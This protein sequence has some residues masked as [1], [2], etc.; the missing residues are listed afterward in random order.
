[1][2]WRKG[3]FVLLGSWAQW[4]TMKPLCVC[5][6]SVSSLRNSAKFS[7]PI[8]VIRYWSS[9]VTVWVVLVNPTIRD[10]AGT[11]CPE[12][13]VLN[14][15]LLDHLPSS[16]GKS[17]EAK[18]P[19]PSRELSRSNISS[20]RSW[21]SNKCLIFSVRSLWSEA[22]SSSICKENR[23]TTKSVDVKQMRWCTNESYELDWLIFKKAHLL[24]QVS[25]TQGCFLFQLLHLALMLFLHLRLG[26][27]LVGIQELHLLM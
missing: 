24:F 25:P 7:Q 12:T 18:L 5:G 13:S 21:R 9:T 22:S 2:A 15:P 8:W 16:L 3:Q 1:M 14:G 17:N 27:V 11:T 23:N 10:S 6:C 26:F 4:C 20:S 19:N